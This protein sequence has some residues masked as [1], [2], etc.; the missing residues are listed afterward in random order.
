LRRKREPVV[1]PREAP[2]VEEGGEV[3]APDEQ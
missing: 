3:G 1:V 2:E